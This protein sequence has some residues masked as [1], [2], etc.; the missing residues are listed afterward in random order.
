MASMMAQLVRNPPSM[1]ETQE[2]QVQ[3]LGQEDPIG[4]G[5]GNRLQYCLKKS[6]GQQSLVGYS[7]KGHKESNVTVHTREIMH[8]P[9]GLIT[10][11][12]YN[13]D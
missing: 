7:S 13:S 10:H 3:S 4:E 11:M 6:H 8:H 9:Q 12:F 5:N 1:H 2:T